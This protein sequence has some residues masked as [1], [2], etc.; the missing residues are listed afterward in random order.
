M[1]RVG[2][3][4]VPRCHGS[5]NNT[6]GPEFVT[7]LYSTQANTCQQVR[8]HTGVVGFYLKNIQK[9]NFNELDHYDH[10]KYMP[11]RQSEYEDIVDH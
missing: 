7:V 6:G 5:N 3:P 10:R 1:M 9:G 2:V 8:D 11:F 4:K